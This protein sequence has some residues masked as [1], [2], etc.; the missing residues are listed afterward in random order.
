MWKEQ[1]QRNLERLCWFQGPWWLQVCC[2]LGLS[3]CTC[4]PADTLVRVYVDTSAHTHTE[5]VCP[6]VLVTVWGNALDINREAY[7]K[8][9]GDLNH[10]SGSKTL[11]SQAFSIS[12]TSV[13][14]SCDVWIIADKS[15]W[16]TVVKCSHKWLFTAALVLYNPF[17]A[18]FPLWEI[19]EALLG[20]GGI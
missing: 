3:I 15:P 19:R 10:W 7:G 1:Q 11:V 13:Y 17:A 18:H 14:I 9:S 6:G 20:S 16:K 4:I 2:C 8:Y 5:R 12:D